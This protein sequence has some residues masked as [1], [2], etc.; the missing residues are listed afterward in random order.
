MAEEIKRRILAGEYKPGERVPGTVS[1]ASEFNVSQSTASRAVT[2]LRA[3]GLVYTVSG[4]GS[5]VAEKS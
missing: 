4:R 1:I 2:S 5:F 3:Q